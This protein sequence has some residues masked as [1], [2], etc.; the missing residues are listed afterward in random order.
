M[1]RSYGWTYSNLLT[2][3]SQHWPKGGAF[4][5]ASADS[6]SL[7]SVLSGQ[8]RYLGQSGARLDSRKSPVGSA[9]I[10]SHIRVLCPQ[11]VS[12][13]IFMWLPADAPWK[14]IRRVFVCKDA[15]T[16]AATQ[17]TDAPDETIALFRVCAT[18]TTRWPPPPPLLIGYIH[19]MA[20]CLN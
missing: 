2:I 16:S 18:A 8:Q 15:Q 12:E 13:P 20:S 1:F 14:P 11:I 3:K 10:I 7:W 4:H 5:L 17:Q 19:R 9:F 6:C